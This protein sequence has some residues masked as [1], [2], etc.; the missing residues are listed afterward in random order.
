MK[1][2]TTD[3]AD[4]ARVDNDQGEAEQQR[5][6]YLRR[7]RTVQYGDPTPQIDRS[8]VP[9]LRLDDAGRAEAARVIALP[10][11]RSGWGPT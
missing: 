9:C 6:A 1:P 7:R 10:R 4:E 3:A 8:D 11:W 2:T 5:L